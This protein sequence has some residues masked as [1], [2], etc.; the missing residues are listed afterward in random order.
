MNRF[1]LCL[2]AVSWLANASAPAGEKPKADEKKGAEAVSVRRPA[3]VVAELANGNARFQAGVIKQ[4]DV[5]ATRQALTGGQHPQAI[6]LSCSD[7]RVPPELVFD[8]TVGDLFVVRT[9]GNVADGLAL[10]L[11]RS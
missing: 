6:V 10:A 8:E 3:E 5:L 4:R 2:V 1:V 7:S 9:A 11:Q